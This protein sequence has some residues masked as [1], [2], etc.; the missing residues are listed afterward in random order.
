MVFLCNGT[1]DPEVASMITAGSLVKLLKIG[2]SIYERLRLLKWQLLSH[3]RCRK[4]MSQTLEC[5]GDV[6]YHHGPIQNRPSDNMSTAICAHASSFCRR[7][8]V[9]ILSHGLPLSIRQHSIATTQVDGQSLEIGVSTL[10]FKEVLRELVHEL[11]LVLDKQ[12]NND[13][14]TAHIYTNIMTMLRIFQ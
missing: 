4:P 8:D 5:R 9:D 10:R 1:Q 13:L 12:H 2:V 6:C 7:T 11:V 14:T 3:H